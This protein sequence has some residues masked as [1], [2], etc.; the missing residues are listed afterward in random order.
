M[1]HWQPCYLGN[2]VHRV[3]LG[4]LVVDV[5]RACSL[6]RPVGKSQRK[7]ICAVGFLTSLLSLLAIKRRGRDIQYAVPVLKLLL[8]QRVEL[9]K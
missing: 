1:S 8:H 4:S 2:L 6:R 9:C 3:G 7:D 5:R